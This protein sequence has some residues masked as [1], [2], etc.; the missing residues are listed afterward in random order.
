MPRRRRGDPQGAQGNVLPPVQLGGV[1]AKVADEVRIAQRSD[2]DW[3]VAALDLPQTGK[4]HVVIMIMRQ[5]HDVR[6]RQVLQ[7]DAGRANSLGTGPGDGGT[8][9]TE[10]RVSQYDDAGKPDQK[11]RMIDEGNGHGAVW[12]CLGRRGIYRVLRHLGRPCGSLVLQP[13]AQY[14][15]QAAGRPGDTGIEEA[16]AVVVVGG[17]V[18]NVH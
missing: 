1:D 11:T 13:P 14:L 5:Q 16:A 7:W 18:G 12:H 4:I 9:F 15:E 2:E 17:R 3:G 10:D 8:A 6:T